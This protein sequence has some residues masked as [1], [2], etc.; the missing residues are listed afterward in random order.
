VLFRS[1]MGQNIYNGVCV[2]AGVNG[3]PEVVKRAEGFPKT[4][5]NWPV[6]PKCLY[7]GPKFLYERYQRPLYIT[8][9]GMACHDTLSSDGKVH[10]PNRIDFLDR[11]LSELK[12][13][14]LDGVDVRGYFQWSLTDNYEWEKGYS[15]RFGLIY[16][17]FQ[18][19]KRIIKDSGHW[20]QKVIVTNGENLQGNPTTDCEW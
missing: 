1:F 20:Y 4:A 7:W 10:D 2:R 12:K 6:T 13:A 19:Q 15:E 14:S 11:Y 9:N 16:V 8:E 5:A 3:K 17:N 18:S